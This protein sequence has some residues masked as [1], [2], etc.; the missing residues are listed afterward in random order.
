LKAYGLGNAASEI[1]ATHF[2]RA[3]GVADRRGLFN[4]GQRKARMQ[5]AEARRGKQQSERERLGLQIAQEVTNALLNIMAAEQNIGTALSALKF[6]QE[7]YRL[8][9]VRYE[10]GKSVVAEVLDAQATRVRAENYVVQS[11]YG[12]NVARDRLIRTSGAPSSILPNLI[13]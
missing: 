10:A 11:P 3:K 6:A 2:R 5:E 4:G 12:Y 7:D 8:A 9:R 1:Q 13:S